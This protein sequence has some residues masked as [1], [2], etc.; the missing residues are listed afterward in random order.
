MAYEEITALLGGWAGFE[1]R[2]VAR[3]PG[4]P[5]VTH[6]GAPQITIE[7][8]AL[9][10]HPRSCS[11]CGRATAEVH[12]VTIRQVRELP[13]LDAETWLLVPQARVRC[14]RCGPTVEAMPWLDRYAR[15]TTRF[16]ESV[17]RLAQVLPVLQ[18]AD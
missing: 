13:I 1:I 5:G 9:P 17:A 18:V 2:A 3:K 15:M 8:A 16:A 12:D 14:P 10:G 7:L 11:R 6:S 4:V